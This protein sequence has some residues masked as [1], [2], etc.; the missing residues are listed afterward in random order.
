M[1]C[2]CSNFKS[3]IVHSRRWLDHHTLLRA[4]F[5]AIPTPTLS[6][7]KARLCMPRARM[8]SN[9]PVLSFPTLQRFIAADLMC[10]P[11]CP[12][13]LLTTS[14]AGTTS[15]ATRSTLGPKVSILSVFR[16]P[17]RRRCSRVI[18]AVHAGAAI[19][20]CQRPRFVLVRTQIRP[21]VCPLDG[22]RAETC[23]RF[24]TLGVRH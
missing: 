21:F 10:P 22:E 3:T 14:T 2:R 15:S 12:V 11:R 9:R 16:F 19:S 24:D 8:S 20:S 13:K 17:V 6:T 7:F 1:V 18:S 5:H 23:L 4:T